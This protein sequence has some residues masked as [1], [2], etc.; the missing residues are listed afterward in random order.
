MYSCL[1]IAWNKFPVRTHAVNKW[2]IKTIFAKTTSPLRTIP[3]NSNISQNFKT[4]SFFISIFVF[5][6]NYIMVLSQQSVDWMFDFLFLDRSREHPPADL[7][8][9]I[10]RTH[11]I[12]A[13]IHKSEAVYFLIS[14]DVSSICSRYIILVWTHSKFTFTHVCKYTHVQ[15][16]TRKQIFAVWMGLYTHVFMGIWY[17]SFCTQPSHTNSYFGI[18]YTSNK[19]QIEMCEG[20][21]QKLMIHIHVNVLNVLLA[22]WSNENMANCVSIIRTAKFLN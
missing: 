20:C 22:I 12:S 16:C 17:T 18:L 5:K 3:P 11:P 4:D 10:I 7:Y 2:S 15:I 14:N 9:Q 8:T 21:V 6:N 19:F 13:K 1:G